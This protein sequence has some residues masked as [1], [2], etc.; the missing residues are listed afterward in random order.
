[1]HGKKFAKF[2]LCST[3]VAAFAAG[4][5][6]S[7]KQQGTA[8][9]DTDNSGATSKTPLE[10]KIHLHY[11]DS[12]VFDNNSPVFAKAAE[13]THVTLKGTASPTATNSKETFN[14]MLVSGN[15]P[16]IIH[17]SKDDMN[18]AALQ[19]ALV[20]LDDLIKQ[21]APHLKK[22]LDDNDWVRKGS[23]ASDGKL[24][25]IPFVADGEASSGFFIR[26]DWLDKLGLP[27][28]KTVDEYYKTLTAFKHQDPNGNGLKD[29]IPYFNRNKAGVIELAQLFG[30]RSVWYEQDGK[31]HFGKYE[32][33]YKTAMSNIA[34]WYKEGLID[35]E[36]YTRG[37]KARDVLLGN[38]TGGS[39][40]DW[41]G[42]TASY[43]DTVKKSV[44][45]IQFV[46]FMP[47]ADINGK[48]K[49]E[50]SRPLLVARGWG[51]SSANKHAVETMKYFDFWFTEEGRRLNNFGLEGTH[52]NMVNGK[53]I[54]KDEVLKNEK[55]VLNQLVEVGAQ[56]EI[57]VNQDFFYEQQWMNPIAKD[58]VNMYINNKTLLPLFPQLTFNEAEQKIISQKWSSIE[59]FIME[60]EQKWIMGV[61]QVDAS[62]DSYLKTLKDMGMD[63]IVKIYNDAYQ[64]YLRS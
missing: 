63:D 16:D 42:S 58:G 53:P 47:P 44:P 20:P 3:L 45:S 11:N 18:K 39:T 12:R 29:E 64:R 49:E 4:C 48:V 22:F 34:K 19:G 56:I 38:N 15:L 43:N 41:F 5:T 6:N 31:V 14:I 52:Y 24:Y 36:I 9:A 50:Q 54:F 7:P 62:F 33:E 55:S 37:S 26:K 59:T 1:M 23:V 28:P 13:L 30:A 17:G 57:G 25:Y 51:I 61:E 21:H 60:K 27:F 8:A 10:L 35:N 46:P 2:V 32:K 40:H